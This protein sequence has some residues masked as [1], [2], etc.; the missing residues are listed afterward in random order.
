MNE[1]QMASSILTKIHKVGGDEALIRF[2]D[3]KGEDFP[4]IKLTSKEMSFLK[5]GGLISWF[6]RNREDIMDIISL[7]RGGLQIGAG[8]GSGN[9]L[10]IANGSASVYKAIRGLCTA[11]E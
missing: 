5:G 3:S 6:K 10:A 4:A 2:F 1:R 11:N 8:I 9:P 7:V